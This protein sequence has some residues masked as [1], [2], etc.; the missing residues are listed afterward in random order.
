M[1]KVNIDKAKAISHSI[2]R[3]VRAIEFA[4]LDAEININIANPEKVAGIESQRQVI[5]DKYAVVQEEI[6]SA[7]T[8]EQLKT[9]IESFK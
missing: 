5:R 8:V 3:E 7:S 4:P 6:N 2:R 1:I 9:I